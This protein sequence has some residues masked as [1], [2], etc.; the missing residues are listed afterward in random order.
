MNIET[1]DTDQLLAQG[2]QMNQINIIMRA[3]QVDV[4]AQTITFKVRFIPTG[5][6]SL[7][8]TGNS[9]GETA[10]SVL[11]LP[12]GVNE[13]RIQFSEIAGKQFSSGQPMFGMDL[14]VPITDGF[15][16]DYPLDDYVSTITIMAQ[17]D[18]SAS[19]PRIGLLIDRGLQNFQ[20]DQHGN[21]S[22]VQPTTALPTVFSVQLRVRRA[23]SV[24]AFAFLLC[25]LMWLLSLASLAVAMD[26]LLRKRRGDAPLIAMSCAL[27][28][29]L[30]ALRNASPGIPQG[31][32][33]YLDLV[34]FVLT[35]LISGVSALILMIHYV[36]SF[37][38]S[39][40]AATESSQSSPLLISSASS[41]AST[42]DLIITNNS[43]P[44]TRSIK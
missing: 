43:L 42:G 21:I 9:K 30:P 15:V 24:A 6:Y 27:I 28:F 7:S 34:G 44:P 41:I 37:R 36:I 18:S 17:F 25:L 23:T 14:V 33:V 29:S 2:N 40:M 1:A 38:D 8:S 10:Q 3:S 39:K 32:I 5:N 4:A 35:M 16:S 19:G 31:S 11:Q 20:V 26:M 22:Q 12:R 13:L